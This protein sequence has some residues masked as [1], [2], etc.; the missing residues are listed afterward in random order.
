MTPSSSKRETR[1]HEHVLEIEASPEEVWNAITEPDELTNWFPL[2]AELKPGA[3]GQL[4]YRWDELEGACE[5]RRW[6]PPRHLQTTWLE[7][8]SED[9][10]R[11]RQ[12]AVDWHIEGEAG[13]TRLRL[14]HSGFGL[15]DDWDEEYN[16]TKRGWTFELQ[17]LK[18]YLERHRGS[19]RSAFWVRHPV[20]KNVG[21][22]WPRLIAPDGFLRHRSLDDAEPGQPV[23]FEL[24]SGDRLTGSVLMAAPPRE[25]AFHVDN[26]NHGL[27]RVAVEYFFG[28]PE[29]VA[30]LSVWDCP[31]VEIAALKGR[32]ARA[33]AATLD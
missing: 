11:G 24:A 6:D 13:R 30:W 4:T 12:L 25:L 28:Q 15:G 32:L 17:S 1:R 22:V 18:H 21:A 10:Q 19:T 33:L 16:G 27:F 2:G 31:N 14:V 3:G 29:A 9:R 20:S 7:P 23:S 26:L 8:L 5:I